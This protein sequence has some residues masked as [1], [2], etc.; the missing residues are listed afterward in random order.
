LYICTDLKMAYAIHLSVV[1]IRM[2]AHMERAGNS[3]Q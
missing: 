3:E 2:N 1:F